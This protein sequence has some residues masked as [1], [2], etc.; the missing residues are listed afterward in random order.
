MGPTIEVALSKRGGKRPAKLDAHR[1]VVCERGEVRRQEA[2]GI[3]VETRR[4]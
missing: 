1:V 3:I 4:S 2:R